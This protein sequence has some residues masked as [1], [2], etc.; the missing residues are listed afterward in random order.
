MAVVPGERKRGCLSGFPCAKVAVVDSR[1]KTFDRMV[2]GQR[3]GKRTLPESGRN[4]LPQ[5]KVKNLSTVYYRTWLGDR[6]RF[7]F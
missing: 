7:F 4:T 6:F 5:K 1:T 3:E 2:V